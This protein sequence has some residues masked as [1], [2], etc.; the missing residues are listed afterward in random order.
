MKQME[1]ELREHVA[2]IEKKRAV[3]VMNRLKDF[4]TAN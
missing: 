3:S 1:E 4:M 2:R